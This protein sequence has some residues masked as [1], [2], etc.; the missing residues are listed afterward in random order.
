MYAVLSRVDELLR[1]RREVGA[2]LLDDG[3]VG[4]CRAALWRSRNRQDRADVGEALGGVE[5]HEVLDHLEL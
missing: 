1:D 3:A 4:C 5:A 2:R